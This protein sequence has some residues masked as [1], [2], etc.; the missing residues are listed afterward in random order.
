MELILLHTRCLSR[1]CSTHTV[2]L[3]TVQYTNSASLDSV[4]HTR[5][6][7]KYAAI[8]LTTSISTDKTEQLL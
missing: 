5:T 6:T 1:L 4:V 3:Y 2:P 7:R 8:T